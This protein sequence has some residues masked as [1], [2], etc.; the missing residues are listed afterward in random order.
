M[1]DG[2]M[3]DGGEGGNRRLKP[4]REL[5]GPGVEREDLCG[6]STAQTDS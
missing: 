5:T 6:T 4:W 2:S 1:E 3:Q